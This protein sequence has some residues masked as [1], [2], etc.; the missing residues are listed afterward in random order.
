MTP[1]LS[2][3]LELRSARRVE[4]LSSQ[5]MND[6]TKLTIWDVAIGQ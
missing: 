3:T 5:L 6:S 2:G 1:G 4:R